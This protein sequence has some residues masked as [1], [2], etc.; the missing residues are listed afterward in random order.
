MTRGLPILYAEDDENDAFL[1]QLAFKN[2]A[3]DWPMKIVHDGKT[4]L[5]YLSGLSKYADRRKHPMPGLVLLDVKMPGISGLEVLR[6]VRQQP[7][8]SSLP[9]LMLTSSAHNADVHQAY[10]IGANGYLVKP[11][12]VDD[13]VKMAKA[14]GDFWLVVNHLPPGAGARMPAQ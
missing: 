10:L 13:M 9:V 2:A 12:K 1:V 5:E 6:W 8:F 11:S 14:I 7:E 3:V 4:A